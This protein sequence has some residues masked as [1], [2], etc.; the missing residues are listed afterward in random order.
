MPSWLFTLA[1]ARD[2]ALLGGFFILFM[3]RLQMQP[4]PIFAG[5]LATFTQFLLI[6]TILFPVSIYD[7]LQALRP[8]LIYVCACSIAF[9]LVD[10]VRHSLPLTRG[11]SSA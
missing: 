2:A 8:P 7:G 11:K 10:Y 9:S 1:L 4:R 6:F 3:R 5:K